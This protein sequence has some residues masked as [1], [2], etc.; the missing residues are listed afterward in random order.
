MELQ[1]LKIADIHPYERNARKMTRLL[2]RLQ[3]LLSNALMLH[4][5]LLTKIM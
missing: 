4:R 3:S 5:L 2:M 1:V